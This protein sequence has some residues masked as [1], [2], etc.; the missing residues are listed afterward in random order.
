MR[1]ISCMPSMRA[2]RSPP[3]CRGRRPRGRRGRGRWRPSVRVH[4]PPA[5][6]RSQSTAL[7]RL[8]DICPLRRRDRSNRPRARVDAIDM[9]R[10]RSSPSAS[11][12]SRSRPRPRSRPA[13]RTSFPPV[14]HNPADRLART[15]DRGLPLRPR[16]ALHRRTRGAG[17]LALQR[18]LAA[19]A[20]G[21][22]WGI[23]RCE[24][25]SRRNYSLHAEGRA[26]DWHLDARNP[27][28]RRAGRRLIRCCW[29]PTAS[30]TRTRS[31]GAWACRRSSGTAARGGRAPRRRSATRPATRAAA[32]RGA[33]W[34]RPPRTATT[35]TS[36]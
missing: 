25:L 18:W 3:A 34:T 19:H 36:G 28:D 4:S 14:P 24:K 35:S 11:P 1:S 33:A 7:P 31:R 29:R 17:A 20:R 2:Q 10:R 9:G 5:P 30:A 27:A 16:A 23:M 8:Q 13:S 26:L 21:Q 15:A 6:P 22:S 12:C 32:S